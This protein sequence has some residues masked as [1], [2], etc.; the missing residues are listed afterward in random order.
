MSINICQGVT[1]AELKGENKGQIEVKGE[2]IDVAKLTLLLRKKVGHADLVSV[3]SGSGK[4]DGGDGKNCSGEGSVVW[5]PVCPY[6]NC[7][8]CNGYCGWRYY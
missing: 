7:Y 5:P 3:S 6:C 1:S 4:G 2:E 8:P